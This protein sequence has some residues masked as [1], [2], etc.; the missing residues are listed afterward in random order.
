[1]MERMQQLED[2]LQRVSAREVWR[3]RV[4]RWVE[5]SAYRVNGYLVIVLRYFNP[6]GWELLVPAYKG[7]KIAQT[8][9]AAD[10]YCETKDN[11]TREVS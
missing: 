9:E 3:K 6:E 10:L 1:M 8:L 11:R 5:A 7:G 2:W 4:D